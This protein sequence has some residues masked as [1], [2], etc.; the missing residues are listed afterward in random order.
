MTVIDPLKHPSPEPFVPRSVSDLESMVARVGQVWSQ[1]HEDVFHRSVVPLFRVWT[2][3]PRAYLEIPLP[4][5]G[6]ARY[7]YQVVDFRA[8]GIWDEVGG[9]LVA[10]MGKFIQDAFVALA[11]DHKTCVADRQLPL[12]IE[13]RPLE[14]HEQPATEA[15]MDFETRQ[16]QP[17]APARCTLNWRVAIPGLED[18]S[19]I[20]NG[21][22]DPLRSFPHLPIR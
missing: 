7:I 22:Q 12:I 16:W 18:L 9:K 20:T 13:R 2:G 6:T 11:Y 17:A 15:G 3:A 8:E 4:G 5:D 10:C 21:V 14:Y 19:T 1:P